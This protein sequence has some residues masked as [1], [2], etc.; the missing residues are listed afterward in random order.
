MTLKNRTILITRP[1]AQAEEFARA[2][3][4]AGGNVVWFP[5]I[6]IS[7][8]ASWMDCDNA[9]RHIHRYSVIVFTSTNAVENFFERTLTVDGR[10]L[11][12][13]RQKSV[14]A[15]GEKTRGALEAHGCVV[16][17][18]PE[19]HTAEELGHLL[20]RMDLRN[21]RILFPH[22]NL[23]RQILPWLL[24][25]SGAT[26]DEVVV[27]ETRK[28]ESANADAIRRLLMQKEIDVVTFFSP[29]SVSNFIEMI[30]V[31]LLDRLTVAAIGE[32]TVETAGRLGVRVDVIP[33][34]AR[35]ESMVKSLEEFFASLP[36][37][38]TL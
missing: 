19:K 27:Y 9:I 21:K 36:E 28:P 14:Y 37:R 32:V 17:D 6:E 10:N 29:S 33:P 20:Q 38:N 7:S 23:S 26:V 25:Q 15:V 1:K 2:I 16:N 18:I 31:G 3:E 22:G 4:L 13:I 8:P 35:A 30:P 34:L 24:R 5:T 11:S 12:A